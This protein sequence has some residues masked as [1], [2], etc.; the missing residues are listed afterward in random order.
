MADQISKFDGDISARTGSILASWFLFNPNGPTA[1]AFGYMEEGSWLRFFCRWMHFS[2]GETYVLDDVSASDATSA[3]FAELTLNALIGLNNRMAMSGDEQPGPGITPLPSFVKSNGNAEIDGCLRF[4]VARGP[5]AHSTDWGR[6]L[7]YLKKYGMDFFGRIGEETRETYEQLLLESETDSR[8]DKDFLKYTWHRH[9]HIDTFQNWHP[10]A[11]QSQ[12]YSEAAFDAWWTVIS[13]PDF[14]REA[15]ANFAYAWVGSIQM[16]EGSAFLNA[17]RAEGRFTA[18]D[19]VARFFDQYH[20]PLYPPEW[21]SESVRKHA[22]PKEEQSPPQTEADQDFRHAFEAY[23]AHDFAEAERLYRRAAEAGVAGAQ[24][25]LAQMYF[26]GEGISRDLSEAAHWFERAAMQ[27]VAQAQHNI[28]LAY[29]EGYGVDVDKTKAAF[30]YEKAAS[31]GMLNSMQ[32]LGLI[33]AHGEG[34]PQSYDR[35]LPWLVRAA[36]GGLADAQQ[37][38]AAFYAN[39]WGTEPDLV[40]ALKWCET[41]SL[42]GFDAPSKEQLKARMTSEQVAEAQSRAQEWLQ[43]FQGES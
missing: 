31:R 34:V 29:D 19:D 5:A 8:I 21:T 32:N 35:A 9:A 13:S 16:V 10:G 39:G 7:Y 30:W 12:P 24:Y 28:G 15:L 6:E 17:V 18:F 26:N 2:G 1:Y 25:N 3:N 36:H 42:R 37:S 41:L 27:D 14:V 33:Y 43:G 22:L 20:L 23:K 4:L 38:A 40:E 11:Y